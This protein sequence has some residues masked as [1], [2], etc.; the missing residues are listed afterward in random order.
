MTKKVKSARRDLGKELE[1]AKPEE[2]E[3]DGATSNYDQMVSTQVAKTVRLK[4]KGRTLK[5]KKAKVMK[6]NIPQNTQ[7]KMYYA[8]NQKK[9]GK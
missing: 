8:S 9:K 7:S 4:G 3:S 6:A 5:A 2:S 1:E